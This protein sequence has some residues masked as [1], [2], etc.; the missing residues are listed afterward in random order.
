M[1]NWKSKLQR[2]LERAEEWSDTFR[3]RDKKFNKG[4]LIT[5]YIGFGNAKKIFVRGRVMEDKGY[6][7][8]KADDSIW[9]NLRNSYQRFETNEIPNAEVKAVFN[10]VDKETITDREGYFRIEL[11]IEKSTGSEPWQDVEFELLKPIFENRKK[12]YA[13]G[14]VLIPPETAR[15]GVISDIDDTILKTDVRRKFKM[16]LKTIFSNAYTREPFDGVAEFYQALQKGASGNENNPIFYVSS[17]PYSLFHFLVKFLELKDIPLGPIFLKDFGTHTPFTSGD[18]KTHKIENIRTVIET[19]PDLQFVLIGD[20]NEQD[21]EIYRQITK[22][23]PNQIKH[24]YI[25]TLNKRTQTEK[26]TE[27]SGDHS[28]SFVFVKCTRAAAEHAAKINLISSHELEKIR[29]KKVLV[30]D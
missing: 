15:F 20:D 4:I 6:R 26:L 12:T 17:S 5:P 11:D 13:T 30:K 8:P 25:R 2:T 21:P 7:E 19:Y 10:G 24:I 23:F 3:Y 22:E 14:Q 1:A 27:E 29:D 9:R 16:I 18:H 28:N